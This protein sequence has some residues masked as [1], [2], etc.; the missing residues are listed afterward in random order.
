MALKQYFTPGGSVLIT[1]GM[2]LMTIAL[3]KARVLRGWRAVSALMV[4]LYFPLQ[5]PLQAMLFLGKGRGP[6]PMLLGIWGFFWLLLGHAIRSFPQLSIP[7]FEPTGSE[8]SG[9]RND[10]KKETVGTLL[11]SL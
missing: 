3:L 1:L 7:G 11:R 4:S 8:K 10:R 2:L 5:F 9:R 6:T